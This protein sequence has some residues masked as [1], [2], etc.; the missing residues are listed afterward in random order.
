[1]E[2]VQNVGTKSAFTPKIF[3]ILL[4]KLTPIFLII[5]HFLKM[6]KGIPLSSKV[7]VVIL[8]S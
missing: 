4:K 2:N 1:M 5:D 3:I 7:E 8:F 6:L